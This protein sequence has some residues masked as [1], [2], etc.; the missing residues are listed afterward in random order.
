MKELQNKTA[1]HRLTK[2]Q[3]ADAIECGAGCK[4]SMECECEDECTCTC[5]C[6][7]R[8]LEDGQL[9]P[10]SMLCDYDPKDPNKTYH[11]G[12]CYAAVFG[13]EQNRC[14]CEFCVCSYI[15]KVECLCGAYSRALTLTPQSPLGLKHTEEEGAM[16]TEAA[17]A[18]DD[19]GS[20]AVFTFGQ[21]D[22]KQFNFGNSN[23]ADGSPKRPSPR[24]AKRIL[25]TVGGGGAFGAAPAG[26]AASG[27]A[28]GGGG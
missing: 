17:A 13:P 7:P 1:I 23:Q 20:A 24:K 15:G 2:Q 16:V 6:E 8:T 22:N 18:E 19:D 4:I 11:T 10:D 25:P 5:T 21:N 28:S 27:S 14:V 12:C 3:L 26:A 9:F